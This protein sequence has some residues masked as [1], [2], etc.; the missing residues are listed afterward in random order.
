MRTVVAKKGERTCILRII[1]DSIP[2]RARFG[3]RPL[4]GDGPVGGTVEVERWTFLRGT[5][6]PETYALQPENRVQKGFWDTS[7]KIFVTPD[8]DAEIQFR[9]R[10]FS[11]GWLFLVLALVLLLGVAGGLWAY[12]AGGA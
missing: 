1:S 3:A 2:Q 7:F 9:T 10:H 5:R 12:F 4:D 6:T 8:R 11:A